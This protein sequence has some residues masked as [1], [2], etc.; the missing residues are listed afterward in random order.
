MT[1]QFMISGVNEQ[2][3]QELEY[4]LLVNFKNAIWTL[5]ERYA[6]KFFFKFEK[7]AMR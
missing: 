7:N 3:H 4:T 2:L 6:I 1:D 5:E